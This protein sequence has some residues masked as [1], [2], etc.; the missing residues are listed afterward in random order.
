[1]AL[2]K[3]KPKSWP[4]QKKGEKLLLFIFLRKINKKE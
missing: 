4:P 3:E 2:E 1:M